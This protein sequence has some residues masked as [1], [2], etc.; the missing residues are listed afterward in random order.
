MYIQV[1]RLVENNQRY[2]RLF[3]QRFDHIN[4]LF[5]GGQIVSA[6]VVFLLKPGYPG[7]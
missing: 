2:E 1:Y 6:A 7:L 3:E 4:V 5:W